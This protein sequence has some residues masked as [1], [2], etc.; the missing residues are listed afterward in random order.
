M[1]DRMPTSNPRHRDRS[2]TTTLYCACLNDHILASID[3]CSLWQSFMI[4]A[5]LS[6]RDVSVDIEQCDDTSICIQ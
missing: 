6:E 2:H 4:N 3:L 5:H 1:N